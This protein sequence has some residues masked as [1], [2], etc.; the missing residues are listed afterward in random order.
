VA[1]SRVVRVQKK[2]SFKVGPDSRSWRCVGVVATKFV[3]KEVGHAFNGLRA[4]LFYDLST[5]YCQK[6]WAAGVERGGVQ[7][8]RQ[9]V[10]ATRPS[11]LFFL[12]GAENWG[13]RECEENDLFSG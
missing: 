12:G 7:V 5:S 10:L 8:V 11:S 6:L 13:L 3:K 2:G 1:R 9:V 4:N